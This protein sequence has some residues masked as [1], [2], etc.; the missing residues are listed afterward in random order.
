VEERLHQARQELREICD[1]F[2]RR[3]S[4]SPLRSPEER[5]E[6]SGMTMT[7]PSIIA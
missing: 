4:R 5:V 2:L 1:G 6:M 7:A 3:E